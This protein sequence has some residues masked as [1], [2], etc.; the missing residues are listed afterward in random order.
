MKN[1]LFG[2]YTRPYHQRIY[3]A[4]FD[5]KQAGLPLGSFAARSSQPTLPLTNSSLP[6]TGFISLGES[7]LT[8]TNG[9]LNHVIGSPL[10]CGVDEKA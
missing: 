5:T 2:T 10:L 8:K 6:L 3:K 7:L 1:C 4:D 9:T